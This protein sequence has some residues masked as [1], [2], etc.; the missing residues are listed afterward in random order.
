MLAT[1]CPRTRCAHECS[2]EDHRKMKGQDGPCEESKARFH[3][4]MNAPIQDHYGEQRRQVKHRGQEYMAR[5]SGSSLALET[6]SD[7]QHSAA[8]RHCGDYVESSRH[9]DQTGR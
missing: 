4:S 3:G 2:P 1:S 7:E 5:A 8:G 9:T 6:N